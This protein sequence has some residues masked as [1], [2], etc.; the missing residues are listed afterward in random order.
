MGR[1]DHRWPMQRAWAALLGVLLMAFGSM[2]L[3]A[4]TVQSATARSDIIADLTVTRLRDL[5]FGQ[6]GGTAGGTVVMT[7][8]TSPTCTPSGALIH[9][10]AC[11]PAEF[12]GRGQ[13]GRI[14][15]I[16]RPA[17]DQ[18]VL[19]GPGADMLITPLSLDGSPGLT[20]VGNGKGFTRYRIT[21][22]NGLF[23]FRLAGTLN[24]GANQTPGVYTGTFE[25]RLD[26]Q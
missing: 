6:I 24:V 21:S 3:S 22:A 10:G 13:S 9:V 25:V 2:P 5:D 17:G 19:T 11:Q 23:T 7:P 15:R 12:G 18:I 14:V 1:N 8:T 20:Y 4:Q 26:Y 16:K